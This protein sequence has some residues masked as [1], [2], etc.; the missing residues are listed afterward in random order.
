MYYRKFC[1]LKLLPSS[2]KNYRK[3]YGKIICRLKENLQKLKKCLRKYLWV[4]KLSRKARWITNTQD[5]VNL[6]ERKEVVIGMGHVKDFWGGLQSSISQS[7][8][9]FPVY[10]SYSDVLLSKHL[11]CEVFLHL[12]HNFQWNKKN[13]NKKGNTWKCLRLKGYDFIKW[14]SL[15]LPSVM[16][17]QG[18]PSGDI[19][20]KCQG[21]R[22][23]VS[24][25]SRDKEKGISTSALESGRNWTN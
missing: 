22:R 23:K 20:M 13:C 21:I 3:N 18:T 2:T 9:F 25:A 7:G 10:F 1:Q 11:F 14:K 4:K 24:K 8:W 15:P 5:G 19:V 6:K 17:G 12:Y 16:D